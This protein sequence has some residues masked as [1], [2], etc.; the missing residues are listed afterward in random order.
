MNAKRSSAVAS[1]PFGSRLQAPLGQQLKLLFAET[2]M[3]PIPERFLR[4]LDLLEANAAE[5][6]LPGQ[7]LA[8]PPS[9]NEV[10]I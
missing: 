2:A 9:S 10:R 7:A 3:A 5:L 1:S 4:L 6:A 8:P